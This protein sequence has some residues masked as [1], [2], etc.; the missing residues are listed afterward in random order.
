M[1]GVSEDAGASF[2][3]ERSEVVA[4]VASPYRPVASGIR[5]GMDGMVHLAQHDMAE[6]ARYAFRLINEK[7]ETV[8]ESLSLYVPVTRAGLAQNFPNPF[9][10]STKIEYWVP[11]DG[12]AAGAAPVSLVIYDVRGARVR[13][14]V[15]TRQ[16]SGRYRVEWDGRDSAGTPVGSGVYFY[17]LATSHFSGTRK[18]LLLK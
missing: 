5:V 1:W 10:P 3:V 12:G 18:M 8:H 15:D 2:S 4:G 16:P 9:N 17:R 6:G 13:T 14:L 7:G 11:G